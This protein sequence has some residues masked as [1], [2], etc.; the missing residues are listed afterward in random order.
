[1]NVADVDWKRWAIARGPYRVGET[2]PNL[3]PDEIYAWNEQ[4]GE[5]LYWVVRRMGWRERLWVRRHWT[6]IFGDT[7]HTGAPWKRRAA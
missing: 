4:E 5:Q 7:G 2:A 6:G 3:A 1:M